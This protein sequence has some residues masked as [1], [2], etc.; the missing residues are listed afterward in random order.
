MTADVNKSEPIEQ[1]TSRAA[2]LVAQHQNRI[3]ARTSRLFTILM[4]VQ[5][6]AGIAA[7]LWISPRTWAGATG[8]VHL[9]VWLA[10]FLGGAITSLPVFLT[11]IRPT[12]TF[13]RHTVAVCQMLMSS[14]LIHLSGGRIETHFHVFGS[15][16]FLAFYRDWRVLVPAT[17]VVAADHALR[18]I[19]FPQSVFGILTASPWRWVEHAAW[20]I[21]EDVILVKMCIQGVQEMWEI[22]TRQASIE[23]ITQG[24]EEKVHTRTAELERAKEAA[25]AANRAKSEFLANMSHEIRTPM[26]GVLGMTELALDTELTIDQRDY[27]TMARSSADA[28]LTVINDILDFSKIEAGML[29]VNLLDFE[30]RENIEETI[31]VLALSAHRKGLELVCDVDC[32]VPDLVVGDALRIR[33]VL[34]NLIGN[35]I[36]FTDQGEVVVRVEAAAANP[37][38]SS[39]VELRFSVRDTGIGISDEKQ[40]AIFHAFE[41]ADNSTTRQYGGTGLGLAISKRL[42]GM[43]GGRIQVESETGRGSIFSFTTPVTVVKNQPAVPKLE[44]FSLRGVP[45]LVVDDN[46]TNRR[47]LSDWLSHWG[48][49]PILAESGGAALK[50]MASLP[51]PVPLVLTDVHMPEMDGFE[52]IKHIKIQSQTPTVIMLTSGSY[53]GDVARSRE[54]GAEAYL[55]KPVRRSDL[56]ATILRILAVHPPVARPVSTWRQSVGSLRRE[57]MPASTGL[58]ILVAEDNVINQKYAIGVLEKEG[59]TSVVVGNGKAAIA[60]LE[61][62]SFDLVLMDVQMPEMDGFEAT[63]AIRAREKFSGGRTPIIAVTAHAMSGDR[64]KCLAAGMDAYISK[65]I[66][67]AELIDAIAA[68]CARNASNAALSP[69]S[70]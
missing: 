68:L 69:R 18:G 49:W 2:E 3:Y 32:S 65:P 33:Q 63:S 29:D 4:I 57:L 37:E 9:H 41:Q 20:V 8:Y 58:H 54:L 7:A 70:L 50:L 36:K 24:L 22:A 21:F 28:L 31:R 27:L 34:V 26:N 16:A 30:P 66:R 60:A 35:A 6:L 43:M 13:T 38:N 62:Q 45:V 11:V 14:L 52:L 25:E 55:I 5:W 51:E 53:P 61:S 46:A 67:S 42:V 1:R 47:M 39:D 17:I 15:L 56:L 59:F 40:D 10:I 19:Y 12:D 23:A 64:D 48:M 44:D